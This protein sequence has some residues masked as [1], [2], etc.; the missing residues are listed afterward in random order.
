[1]IATDLS[2]IQVDSPEEAVLAW[3]SRPGARYLAGGTEITTTARRSAAYP[4]SALIDIKGL[5]ETQTL[6]VQE[7]RIVLG[8]ALP[9]SI[10]EDWPG[11]PLLSATVRG[12]ADRT[13]RNRL[14]L[15]GNIIGMLPYREA[16][17][18]LLLADSS[19]VSVVPGPSGQAP[20]RKQWRLR[21]RFDKRL[22]LEPG[23]LVLSFSLPAAFAALPWAHRRKTRTGPVDYPLVTLCLV[24]EGTAFR[25]ALSGAHPYPLR[26]DAAD[27]G[28]SATDS[29]EPRPAGAFAEAR[30]FGD[31]TVS[32]GEDFPSAVLTALDAL[33]APRSDQRAS[34]DY[35]AQL[36][37]LMLGSALEELS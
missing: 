6:E 16:V 20:V 17:L 21:D 12:I 15:G 19:G 11:F 5:A 33:G 4:L 31:A 30:P 28:L 37:R 32:Q 22:V 25:L 14:S 26:S 36:L 27:A 10:V 13:V 35:R 34:G 7:N 8:A 24:R 23:E 1:M 2:Y 3:S 18:P 29:A 9:L